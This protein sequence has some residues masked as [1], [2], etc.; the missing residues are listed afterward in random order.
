MDGVDLMNKDEALEAALEFV[1]RF[2]D[3][4]DGP[5][6]EPVPNEAMQIA[7]MIKEALS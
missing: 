1:E 4:C 5:C 7:S 3:V 6:G 2:S